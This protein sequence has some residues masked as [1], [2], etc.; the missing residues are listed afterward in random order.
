MNYLLPRLAKQIKVLQENT[1]KFGLS[2]ETL[3]TVIT[4]GAMLKDQGAQW[5][6]FWILIQIGRTKIGSEGK[7]MI[8]TGM[9]E[10]L[11]SLPSE[12]LVEILAEIFPV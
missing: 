12:T 5:G 11:S 6:C 10:D 8:V 1:V 3:G 2:G 7:K 9:R 4:E